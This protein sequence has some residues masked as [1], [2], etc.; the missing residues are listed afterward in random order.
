MNRLLSV[1]LTTLILTACS[2]AGLTGVDESRAASRSSQAPGLAASQ[3]Q[4]AAG[5]LTVMTRNVY[6]GT[7][8]DAVIAAED[9]NQ[10]P[11]IAAEVWELP[12][13]S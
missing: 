2:D 9:P 5:N 12:F 13:P 6:V 7:D 4:N 8:V 1:T 3:S 10:I 11:F